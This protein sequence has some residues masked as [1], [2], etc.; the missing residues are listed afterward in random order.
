MRTHAGTA[1]GRGKN[2]YVNFTGVLSGTFRDNVARAAGTSWRTLEKAE[3]VV[4]AASMHPRKY[5]HLVE[6]NSA[7]GHRGEMSFNGLHAARYKK[8]N[9]LRAIKLLFKKL[10]RLPGSTPLPK[11]FLFLCL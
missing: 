8:Q 9:E 5:G 11:L 2:T 6:H 1:P 7:D 10:N 3:A 4:D